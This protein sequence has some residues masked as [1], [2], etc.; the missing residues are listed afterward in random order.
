VSSRTSRCESNAT[1]AKQGDCHALAGSR[2]DVTRPTKSA[3]KSI[4]RIF[5]VYK[6]NI[7]QMNIFQCSYSIIGTGCLL[8]WTQ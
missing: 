5:S 7:H 4:S 1:A 6:N 3:I 8:G 2:N